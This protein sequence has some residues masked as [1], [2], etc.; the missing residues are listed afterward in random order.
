MRS[1]TKTLKKTEG[2]AGRSSRCGKSFAEASERVSFT[3][4]ASP[5]EVLDEWRETDHP[6]H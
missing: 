4:D 1:F 3:G 2:Y 6:R 5:Y